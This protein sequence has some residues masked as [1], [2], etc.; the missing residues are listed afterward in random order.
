MP[1][2]DVLNCKADELWS[3]LDSEEPYDQK[4]WFLCKGIGMIELSQLGEL[5]GV[6]SYDNLMAGLKL[7]GEPRDEGPWPQTVPNA[8]TKR[9]AAITDGEIAAVVPRWLESE[10][11]QGGSATTDSL[12][13]YLERLRS[14]VSERS[15]EFFLVNAL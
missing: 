7:V 6:D 15:G 4:R 2:N 3:I 12:T 9:L 11:F 14:F 5:L 10:Q 8:L 1:L 13:N